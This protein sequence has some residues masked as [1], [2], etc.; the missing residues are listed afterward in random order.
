MPVNKDIYS[1]CNISKQIG[2][3]SSNW[4]KHVVWSPLDRQE[5]MFRLLSCVTGACRHCGTVFIRVPDSHFRSRDKKTPL[6]DKPVIRLRA[7]CWEAGVDFNL[8]GSVSQR[9]WSLLLNAKRCCAH[10]SVT[11][12]QTSPLAFGTVATCTAHPA[13]PERQPESCVT[14]QF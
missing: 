7:L 2:I 14:L 1:P 12:R 9:V 13:T 6:Q 4:R 11:N 10:L 3:M 8:H 5:L